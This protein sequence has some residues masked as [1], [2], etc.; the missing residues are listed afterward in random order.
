[1]SKD[2]DTF[3]ALLLG[4]GLAYLLYQGMDKDWNAFKEK[5]KKRL[6]RLKHDTIRPPLDFVSNNPNMAIVYRESIFCYLFGLPN[7]CIPSLV[8]VLEQS[9]KTKYM[10]TEGKEPSSKMTL[11][12]LIDWAEK[13]LKDKTNVAHSF[14]MLRNY[15]HTDVLID[16]KDCPEA[17][18]HITSIINAL[19]GETVR[20][21]HTTCTFCSYGGPTT[22]SNPSD[23]FIG[24]ILPVRCGSCQR[25]YNWIIMP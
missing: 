6:E 22:F 20:M 5:F 10:I 11:N 8:R 23:L 13:F 1:M 18:R 14:R 9:L 21:L 19:F 16:E 24:N 12:D 7:S 25:T 15:V 17:I 4:G 3:L 2:D